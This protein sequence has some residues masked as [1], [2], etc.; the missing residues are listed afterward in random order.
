MQKRN[1]IQQTKLARLKELLANMRAVGDKAQGLIVEAQGSL[2]ELED[3]VI[4]TSADLFTVLTAQDYQDITG[5]IILKIIALLKDLESN[6][7]N[8]IRTFGVRPEGPKESVPEELYGPAHAGV[9][10][11]MHSQDDVDS[12]LA[13]FGF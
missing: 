5:Q 13:E 1:Q 3:S 11:A 2:A 9:A 7:V 10:T 4:K 8:V 6:L 12:L